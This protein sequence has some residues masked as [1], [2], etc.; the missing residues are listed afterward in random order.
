MSERIDEYKINLLQ[1]RKFGE[2]R[3]VNIVDLVRATNHFSRI[4]IAD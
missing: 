3:E 4:D 1:Q 2:R